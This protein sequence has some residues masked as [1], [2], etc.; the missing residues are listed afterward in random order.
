[1]LNTN[2]IKTTIISTSIIVT[3]FFSIFSSSFSE[4]FAQNTTTSISNNNKVNEITSCELIV[5]TGHRTI[6]QRRFTN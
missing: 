3:L 5:L 6:L 4:S 1:M 2:I